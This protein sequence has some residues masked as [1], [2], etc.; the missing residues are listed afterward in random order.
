MA[1]KVTGNQLRA[2]VKLLET[3]LQAAIHVFEDSLYAFSDEEKDPIKAMD[4]IK[5][6]QK[7]ISEVQELQAIY[8]LLV[9]VPVGTETMTLC[10]AVKLIG[11]AGQSAS[12]WRSAMPKKRDRYHDPEKTR[13]VDEET[14]SLTLSMEHVA[15]WLY[16]AQGYANLLQT[17]IAQG[18]STEVP[19]DVPEGLL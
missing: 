3:K 6:I 16:T 15:E 2:A 7:N 13:R 18:N 11:M 17:A 10:R 8:N 19:L 1:K 9:T 12:L 5:E 14:S 4:K